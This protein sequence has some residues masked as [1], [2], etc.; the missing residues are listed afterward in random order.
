[1]ISGNIRLHVVPKKPKDSH[2]GTVLIPISAK[3]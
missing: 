1:M 3:Y 2:F